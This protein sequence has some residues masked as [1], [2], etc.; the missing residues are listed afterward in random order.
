[1]RQV[2][3][4]Q[5]AKNQHDGTAVP[6]RLV[7]MGEAFNPAVR[8]PFGRGQPVGKIFDD[9]VQVNIRALQYSRLDRSWRAQKIGQG[10]GGSLFFE[11]IVQSG[12]HQKNGS[13]KRVKS[14]GGQ[15]LLPPTE[16]GDGTE[17][18]RILDRNFQLVINVSH[19][20]SA[21]V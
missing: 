6:S 1:M 17:A 15:M 21:E 9:A 4:T 2:N 14:P 19:C 18:R 5:M 8:H 7:Q 10:G 20:C 11:A 3:R 13:Q 16:N 12:T